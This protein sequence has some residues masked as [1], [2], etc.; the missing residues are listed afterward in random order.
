MF[1]LTGL[2]KTIQEQQKIINEAIELSRQNPQTVYY[3][4]KK[5]DKLFMTGSDYVK[6][7]YINAKC[8]II[9]KTKGGLFII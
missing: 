3:I 9:G 2:T 5:E 4:F 1:T 8:E 6:Q 7:I